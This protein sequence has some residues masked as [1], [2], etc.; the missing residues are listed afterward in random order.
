[1][2]LCGLLFLSTGRFC[3][4]AQ[5]QKAVLRRQAAIAAE[6]DMPIVIHSRDSERDII[7]EL[8]QVCENSPI[9]KIISIYTFVLSFILFMWYSLNF[10]IMIK[11][12]W[13]V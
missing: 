1:M 4:H 11:F 13:F 3:E 7:E 6:L 5:Q 8:Q 12:L 9:F 10:F 2:L